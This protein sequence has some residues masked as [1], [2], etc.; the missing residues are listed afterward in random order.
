MKKIFGSICFLFGAY[1]A[2]TSFRAGRLETSTILHKMYDSIRNVKTL[3]I[4]ITAIERLGTTYASAGSEVKLQMNPRRL[5]FNNKAK[6]L[7]ILFNQ[8]TNNNKALVKPNHIPNLNLD[9]NGNMMRKNQHYTI[10]E[11]GFDFIGRSIALTLS[12]DK[13]GLKNFVYKGKSKKFTYNC[14]LLQ[15]ENP[16]YAYV[17]YTVGPKETASSIAAKL[18]VNDY[19]LRHKNDLLN[20]FGFLKKGRKILVPNLYCKKAV[21]F[22]DEKLM[23]PV[24][25]SLYDDSGLFESYEY[26]SMTINPT[27]KAEE[28]S[29][30]NK[31]YGFR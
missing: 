16:N 18:I 23:L 19:L 22:I 11:L 12:K 15:Y 6:K 1:L 17:E 7:E 3:K 26:P 5:Y 28:F 13:E 9:P 25:V 21:I 24:S 8:N 20:D 27:I 10:H 30:D 2:L 14:Y 29:K 31:E 4:T